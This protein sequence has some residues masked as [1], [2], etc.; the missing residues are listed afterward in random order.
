MLSRSLQG[1]DVWQRIVVVYFDRCAINPSGYHL[2]LVV[3]SCDWLT[4]YIHLQ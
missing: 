1:S 4:G 2:V 3:Y